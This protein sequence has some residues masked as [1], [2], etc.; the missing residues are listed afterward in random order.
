MS[1][2]F[3]EK[4]RTNTLQDV[5]K[6]MMIAAR[7]AP[8]GK[9]VDNLLIASVDKETI[10]IIAER[11]KAMYREGRAADF[12]LRDAENILNC[13]VLVLIGTRIAPLKVSHCGLCGFRDCDE[14]SRYPDIPCSFNMHDLGVAVGSAVSI[15]M[16]HRTDNRIMFSVGKA[17]KELNLLGNEA[18]IIFGI[19]LSATGKNIFFDRKP[20]TK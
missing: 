10:E 18:K 13:E 16:D 14:K 8:K 12:F 2:S 19:P 17:A 5:A 3:E 7:T 15:A 20:I 1:I 11:M 4:E 9:G 6:K